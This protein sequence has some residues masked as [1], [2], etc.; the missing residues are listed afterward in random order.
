MPTALT[1]K[2]LLEAHG[3][4]FNP[5]YQDL[6]ALV[7]KELAAGQLL[8][9]LFRWSSWAESNET[10]GQQAERGG[11]IR[12]SAKD[13][14]AELQF[15]R[16]YYERARSKLRE[17]GIVQCRREN[18]VHGMMTWK[19]NFQ[20]LTELVVTRVYGQKIP[21]T[22]SGEQFDR[23]HFRLPEFIPLDLWQKHQKALYQK[24]RKSCTEQDKQKF[25][26]Q[27]TALHEKGL[28]IRL[29]MQRSIDN[30]WFGFFEPTA[31][32]APQSQDNGDA[33]SKAEFERQMAEKHLAA[34]RPPPN[35]E[36]RKRLMEQGQTQAKK[37]LDSIKG[38]K[39]SKR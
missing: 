33:A 13:L 9:C 17:L 35:P 2:T 14:A 25:V 4:G 32:N 39:P 26:E 30:A 10:P 19:V 5:S 31:S 15:T 22:E 21:K 6:T 34:E 27:L 11:W 12:K 18:A 20:H 7:G 23:D 16:S 29:I 38:R 3:N 24:K 37:L 36:E 8:A 28:D 1:L